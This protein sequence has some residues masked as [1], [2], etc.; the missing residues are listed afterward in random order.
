MLV[1]TKSNCI[2]CA[3]TGM[4]AKNIDGIT[5]CSLLYLPIDNKF[6]ELR[7]M[8]LGEIQSKFT[9]KTVL[10]IDE[11]SMVGLRTFGFIDSRLRQATGHLQEPFGGVSVI[12]VGDILQLPPVKDS[13]VFSIPKPNEPEAIQRGRLSF[14][15]FQDVV[16]LT[17]NQRQSEEGQSEFVNLLMKLRV[18]KHDPEEAYHTLQCRMRG[19][20]NNLEQNRFRNAISLR[21][22]NDKVNSANRDSLKNLKRDKKVRICRID[23]VIFLKMFTIFKFNM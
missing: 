10:I 6:Q 7:G 14:L 17:I 19:F 15:N 11:Y 20:V 2:V 9:R 4:A 8:Q 22:S 3:M 21:F 1:E 5:L 23:A 16:K 13:S 12:I 18:G